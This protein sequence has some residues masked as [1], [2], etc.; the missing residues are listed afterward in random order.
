MR[1]SDEYFDNCS[2]F[3]GYEITLFRKDQGEPFSFRLTNEEF[4][5]KKELVI[6]LDF[7][8]K[9]NQWIPYNIYKDLCNMP[10]M[11]YPGL[12]LI[13]DINIIYIEVILR[14]KRIHIY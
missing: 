11:N 13:V 14:S 9:T 6:M 7:L 12:R 1:A 2:S 10:E 5:E 4:E 8:I 3:E